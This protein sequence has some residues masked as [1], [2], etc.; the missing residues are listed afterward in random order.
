LATDVPAPPEPF[1]E[2]LVLTWP[3]EARLWHA[4]GASWAP[5]NFNPTETSARF[6]P[7]R[8][9]GGAIVPTLYA[10]E[11]LETAIAESALHDVSV[12]LRPCGIPFAAVARYAVV[13]LATARPL[14]LARLQGPGL[15]R[16]SLLPPQLTHTT[17]R[18]YPQTAA[19]AKRLHDHAGNVDGIAWTSR[20][21]DPRTAIMLFGDRVPPAELAV[22]RGPHPLGAEPVLS[23]LLAFAEQAD[24]TIYR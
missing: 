20:L 22:V 6:R 3:V 9:R 2:P 18:D 14:R 5:P 15:G 16:Y 10:G 23:A 12:A 1:P 24:I 17:A 8:D 13:E 7:V 4:H 19:W 21:N 11:D